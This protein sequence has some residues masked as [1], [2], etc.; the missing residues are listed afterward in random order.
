LKDFAELRGRFSRLQL[1]HEPDAN[2][3]GTRELVLSHPTGFAGCPN[4]L[5]HGGGV[6]RA[7]SHFFPDRETC[8]QNGFILPQDIPNGKET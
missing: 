2:S 7:T 5:A 6:Q 3:G 8:L 4:N 1:D